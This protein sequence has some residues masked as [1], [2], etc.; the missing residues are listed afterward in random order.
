MEIYK[1]LCFENVTDGDV[2]AMTEIMKRAFDDDTK[3]HTDKE[4]D[5]PTGYDNGD[6]I[7]RWYINSDSISYKISKAGVLIGGVS[8]FINDNG[9]NYLGNIFIDPEYHNTGCG[10]IIWEFIEKTYPETKKWKTE[11]PGYS[12]RN[13]YFYI[14]KCGFRLVRIDNSENKQE[15]VYFLEKEYEK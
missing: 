13:H 12:K 3:R 2:A 7:R 4:H 8:V 10:A 5:G 9:E 14:N 1:N 11:T 15:E 6:F